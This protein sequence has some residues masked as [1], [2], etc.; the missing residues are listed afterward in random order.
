MNGMQRVLAAIRGEP[1]DRIPIFC[2]LLDQGARELGISLREYYGSGHHV[3][4]GQLRMRRKYG[5]DNVWALMYVGKEAELLG[6]RKILFSEDGPPNVEDF[7][8]KEL[9]DISRLEVPDDL[10]SHPAFAETLTCLR[11]LRQEV[12]GSQPICAYLT[13]SLSLPAILMGMERWLELLLL[14][15]ASLR[16]ELLTKCSDFF[17]KEIAAF[18]KAGA[19]ILIYSNPFGSTDTL[20]MK[21]FQELAIPWMERDLGPG[22]VEGV[23]YYCGS[24]RFN[25]VID[26]VLTRFGIGT[27]YL[28]PLDDVGEGKA[29]I[30]GRGL[31][32]GVINDIPLVHWSAEE[33]DRQVARIIQA[34]KPGGKFLFGTLLMPLAIPE[35]KIRLL[36]DAALRHGAW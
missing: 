13:A 27:Y 23:V 28:S 32:C 12:G 9:A 8:I 4:E 19:D 35:P 3:A 16:D 24:S 30:A 11:I 10:E 20:S 33:I 6:S 29:I 17:R 25:R 21:L 31:T 15:P 1:A 22:G 36:M 18:R 2:N 14:G 7:V 34:G 26:Q 5:H